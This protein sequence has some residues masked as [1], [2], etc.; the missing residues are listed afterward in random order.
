MHYIAGGG[1][2]AVSAAAGEAILDMAANGRCVACLSPRHVH[3]WSEASSQRIETGGGPGAEGC[4]AKLAWHPSGAAL[5]ILTLESDVLICA[6]IGF[7]A[8]EQPAAR[9]TSRTSLSGD[10]GAMATGGS[11]VACMTADASAILVSHTNGAPCAQAADRALIGEW[12]LV[13]WSGTVLHRLAPGSLAAAVG[14]GGGVG[15]V[16][17]VTEMRFSAALQAIAL[18]VRHTIDEG[19]DAASGGRSH[20]GFPHDD[21]AVLLLRGVA[22][23]RAVASLASLPSSATAQRVVC[24]HSGGATTVALCAHR[25]I[26]AVGTAAATVHTYDLSPLLC[27]TRLLC[28]FDPSTPYH[29]LPHLIRAHSTTPD[30]STPN[31]PPLAT[32]HSRLRTPRSPLPAPTPALPLRASSSTEYQAPFYPNMEGTTTAALLLPRHPRPSRPCRRSPSSSSVCRP[33]SRAASARSRSRRMA[34][35]SRVGGRGAVVPSGA[36]PDPCAAFGRGAAAT[37][38]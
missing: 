5:A 17:H 24:L 23:L 28:P 25:S 16:G 7:A 30:P 19:G 22:S 11:N 21:G 3:L 36:P 1:V 29:T 26:C 18:L 10:G 37:R 14:L 8:S 31:H 38:S 4:N 35:R 33:R 9:I 27:A 6:G 12:C 15:A 32:R 2:S 13:S 34:T 20:D